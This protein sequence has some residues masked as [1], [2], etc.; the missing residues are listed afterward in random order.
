M[1]FLDD[2]VKTIQEAA[3]EAKR[4]QRRQQQPEWT[5]PEATRPVET[6]TARV[7]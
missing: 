7:T 3:E 4:Q 2:L 1:G 6:Q 5:A